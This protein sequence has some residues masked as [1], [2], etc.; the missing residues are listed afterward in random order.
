VALNRQGFTV[1][2]RD[3]NCVEYAMSADGRLTPKA[4]L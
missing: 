2:P 3:E 4:S 1:I